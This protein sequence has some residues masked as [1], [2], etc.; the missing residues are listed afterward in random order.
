MTGKA[1]EEGHIRPKHGTD[2]MDRVEHDVREPDLEGA[3]RQ[4]DL[5]DTAHTA[6]SR[7]TARTAESRD[8]ARTAES[9]DA[10]A[11]TAVTA[12]AGTVDDDAPGGAD[13]TGHATDG[14]GP[15][16]ASVP[17]A[18]GGP[19]FVDPSGRRANGLRRMGWLV[20]VGCVCSAATLGLAVT[21]GN[22]TA[23]WLQI[24]GMLGGAGQNRSVDEA[25]RPE[26]QG[27]G[28]PA[29]DNPSSTAAGAPTRKGTGPTDTDVTTGSPTGKKGSNAAPGQSSDSSP[30]TRASDA[31]S[32]PA[33]GT[34]A[35]AGQP[36]GAASPDVIQEPTTAPSS[37][38]PT[39]PDSS[40]EPSPTG[41]PASGLLDGLADAVSG[42]FGK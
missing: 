24:P 29:A 32:P 34:E 25:Q 11:V 7:D 15:A 10:D 1:G 18:G 35:V 22:S 40:T 31:A 14:F 17:P 13:S 16:T 9:R 42:L 30:S 6:E 4:S 3:A 33:G 37:A 23:P 19:V 28:A 8:T 41:T 36:S 21:G 39:P 26:Q 5:A 38:D 12:Q 27:S 2:V 20:A